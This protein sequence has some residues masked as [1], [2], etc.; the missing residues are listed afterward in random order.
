MTTSPPIY[1]SLVGQL[2]I[3]TPQMDD[4]QFQ[5]AVIYICQHDS[6]GAMGL[7][8]NRPINELTFGDLTEKLDIGAPRDAADM[9]LFSGG[10]VEA[11]RGYI[12]HS[13]DQMMPETI[14]LS[15]DIALSLHL[16]MLRDIAQGLGPTQAKIMLGYA[17]WGAGQLEDELRDNMWFHIPAT[18]ELVFSETPHTLWNL[19]FKSAGLNAGS[20]SSQAGRA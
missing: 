20:L 16:D 14:A 11:K 8:I 5:Q 6:E 19:G 3:A 4:G 18:P 7:I 10:P 12:L 2:L 15:D 13:Q 9:L 1:T 17:G